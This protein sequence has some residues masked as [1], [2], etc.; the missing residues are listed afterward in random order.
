MTRATIWHNPRCSKSRE[1]KKLLEDQGVELDVRLYLED[2]PSKA[3][4]EKTLKQLGMKPRDLLRTKEEAYAEAGLDDEG[5]SDDRVLD[6]MIAHP[7]LIERPVVVVGDKAVLGRPP[8]NALEL[9][10]RRA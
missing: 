6:A 5:L 2:P 3:L 7:I 1:T 10:A 8:E 4:L 9:L